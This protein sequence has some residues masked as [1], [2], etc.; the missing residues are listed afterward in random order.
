MYSIAAII[1][2]SNGFEYTYYNFENLVKL[3]KK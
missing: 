2:M 1:M 3:L